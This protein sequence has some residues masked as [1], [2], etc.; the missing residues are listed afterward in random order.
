MKDGRALQYAAAEFQSDEDVVLEAGRQN[1]LAFNH[2]STKFFVDAALWP[3]VQALVQ[4]YWVF[5]VSILSGA[6]CYVVATSHQEVFGILVDVAAKLGMKSCTGDHE[7]YRKFEL[8]WGSKALRLFR[9][10]VMWWALPE[11]KKG[12]ILDLALIV[13]V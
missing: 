1:G 3:T 12:K 7:S 9:A 11:S 13:R 4:E 6:S 8:L 10:S 5:R 2:A